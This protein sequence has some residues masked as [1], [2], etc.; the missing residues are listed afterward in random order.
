MALP[1]WACELTTQNAHLFQNADAAA[2]RDTDVPVVRAA[3][4]AHIM[5][6]AV[7]ALN[8]VLSM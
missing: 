7:N 8:Q 4:V 1:I 2:V 3:V 5:V 6:A